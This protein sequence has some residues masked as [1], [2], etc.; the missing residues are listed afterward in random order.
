MTEMRRYISGAV[1]ASWIRDQ[2]WGIALDDVGAETASL[3]LMPFLRPDI[4]KLA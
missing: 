3:A 1:H 4:I 2:G